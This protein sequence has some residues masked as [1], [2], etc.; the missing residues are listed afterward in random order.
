MGYRAF[1]S[2]LEIDIDNIQAGGIC[3]RCGQAWP[4]ATLSWQYESRGPTLQNTHKLV[5]PSCLDAPNPSLRTIVL[6]PDPVPVIN[7]RPPS[8][9]D[10]VTIRTTSSGAAR[11]TDDGKTRTTD[12]GID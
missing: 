11:V 5:C 10:L 1:Q 2:H 9:N 12:E 6:P 4:H 7:A 8:P 3:D